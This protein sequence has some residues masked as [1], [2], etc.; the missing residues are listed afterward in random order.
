[1]QFIIFIFFA[2]LTVVPV[3]FIIFTR[4]T[5]YAAVALIFSFSGVAGLYALLSAPF[6]SLIQILVYA[7]AIMVLFVFAIMLV[8]LRQRIKTR[9]PFSGKISIILGIILGIEIF[10]PV[11][12]LVGLKFPASVPVDVKGIGK[13]LFSDY[14]YPFELTSLLILAALVTGIIISRRES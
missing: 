7:G 14:L 6:L 8:D 11:W 1:M 4:N 12:N 5:L 2:L 3:F 13:A 10:L 9:T